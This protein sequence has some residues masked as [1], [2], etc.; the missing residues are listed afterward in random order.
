MIT[1]E[2]QPL[3]GSSSQGSR[4][5]IR[6][7]LFLKTTPKKNHFKGFLLPCC[8][9]L[10]LVHGPLNW[11]GLPR[12][13]TTLAS[14][15]AHS[16]S[17][18]VAGRPPAPGRTSGCSF[19]SSPTSPCRPSRHAPLFLPAHAGRLGLLGSTLPSSALHRPPPH[20]PRLFLACHHCASLHWGGGLPSLEGNLGRTFPGVGP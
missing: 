10:R 7:V 8:C 18:G 6:Q 5:T 15:A 20:W 3:L 13:P 14:N 12:P 1:E 16:K 19:C 2:S 9:L 4:A 11:L 17:G